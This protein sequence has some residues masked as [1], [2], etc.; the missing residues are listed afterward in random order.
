MRRY[1]LFLAP[2]LLS[3][4]VVTVIITAVDAQLSFAATSTVSRLTA[5][6][7]AMPPPKCVESLLCGIL[8]QAFPNAYST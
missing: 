3:T 7:L 8:Q 5:E 6:P 1:A 2:N 4:F